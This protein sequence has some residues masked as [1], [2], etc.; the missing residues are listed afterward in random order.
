MRR[1][2]F[3][4]LGFSSFSIASEFSGDADKNA[5]ERSLIEQCDKEV[6]VICEFS[7]FEIEKERECI[8]TNI[9][10]LSSQCSLR[11]KEAVDRSRPVELPKS[12]VKP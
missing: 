8:K 12:L 6:R 11:I 1:L 4:L 7:P 2:F 9:D 10:N 5:A 3:I